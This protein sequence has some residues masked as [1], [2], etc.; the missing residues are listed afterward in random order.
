MGKGHMYDVKFSTS[1]WGEAI[2]FFL[3]HVSVLLFCY[4][5]RGGTLFHFYFDLFWRWVGPSSRLGLGSVSGCIIGK[6]T[7]GIMEMD[8]HGTESVELG[9][10]LN[11]NGN[12]GSNY[13]W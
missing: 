12:G 2:S 9:T 1:V 3:Q 13:Y 5:L 4:G 11:G 8:L 6:P 7:R 10:I